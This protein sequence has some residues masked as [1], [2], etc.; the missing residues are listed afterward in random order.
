MLISAVLLL[1]PAVPSLGQTFTTRTADILLQGC[2]TRPTNVKLV[3]KGDEGTSSGDLTYAGSDH[4]TAIHLP[5][6][7]ARGTKASLRLGGARTKCAT[8][9]EEHD[10]H[11]ADSWIAVFRFQCVQQPYWSSL[12]IETTPPTVPMQYTRVMPDKR[13]MPD[14]RAIVDMGCVEHRYEITGT[15]EINDVA[16]YNESIYVN[17][18]DYDPLRPYSDYAVAIQR[19]VFGTPT[20][21]RKPQTLGRKPLALTR[22]D[23]LTDLTLRRANKPI[24]SPTP[25]DNM[26]SVRGR[27]LVPFDKIK[28]TAQ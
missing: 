2:K 4:W 16:I 21:G 24:A 5:K 19:G 26:R 9:T 11:D 15:A 6:F 10:P 1:L 23:V 20:L 17:L 22:T 12:S 7:N 14:G 28:M 25:S 3:L 27:D 8:S 13:V 18:G